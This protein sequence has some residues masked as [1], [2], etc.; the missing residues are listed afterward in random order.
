[1]ANVILFLLGA[2]SVGIF[3]RRQFETPTEIID[4]SGPDVLISAPVS[5]LAGSNAFGKGL[6]FYIIIFEIAYVI[7]SSSSVLLS[8]ALQAARVA[9]PDVVG[10]LDS[11]VQTR[12]GANEEIAGPLTESIGVDSAIPLVVATLII[13]FSSTP[14]FSEIEGLVRSLA[15]SASGIPR[16]IYSAIEKIRNYKFLAPPDNASASIKMANNIAR[17]AKTKALEKGLDEVNAAAMEQALA[18]LFSLL[19]WVDGTLVLFT[20]RSRNRLA[21]IINSVIPAA[22]VLNAKLDS[23]IASETATDRDWEKISAISTKAAENISAA[24]GLLAINDYG[25][26]PSQPAPMVSELLKEIESVNE[27]KSLNAVIGTL[28]WGTLL[29]AGM[30]FL[31]RTGSNY[32]E[33]IF[34]SSSADFH[35]ASVLYNWQGSEFRS[36]LEFGLTSTFIDV[37]YNA[38][39]FGVAALT[40]L[41]LRSNRLENKLWKSYSGKGTHYFQY[42]TLSLLTTFI[43]VLPFYLVVSALI[44]ALPSFQVGGWSSGIHA[45]QTTLELKSLW[46]NLPSIIIG[47]P[48]IW[49]VF[50]FTDL[51]ELSKEKRIFFKHYATAIGFLLIFVMLAEGGLTEGQSVVSSGIVGEFSIDASVSFFCHSAF[52]VVLSRM[53]LKQNSET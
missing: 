32:Y 9:D 45:M 47:L 15:H 50:K 49:S 7:L 2:I 24:F 13:T 37:F 23:L 31:I 34:S 27:P 26:R 19:P 36:A 25:A 51:V 43:V 22:E 17:N 18:R 6:T 5:V 3:A 28:I 53:I 16:N 33:R 41:S 48:I 38:T 21:V 35:I 39:I 11:V 10:F 1:M 12:E 44:E 42:T 8:L 29:A 52:L 40:A 4:S 20:T 46:D 30:T 14:P